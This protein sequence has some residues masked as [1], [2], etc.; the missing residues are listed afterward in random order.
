MKGRKVR[1]RDFS[2]WPHL[3]E[4]ERCRK[5]TGLGRSTILSL[6]LG[7]AVSLE[8]LIMLLQ[9]KHSPEL[10]TQS[11]RSNNA[12]SLCPVAVSTSTLFSATTLT[13]KKIIL[14]VLVFCSDPSSPKNAKCQSDCHCLFKVFPDA[15]NWSL[16]PRWNLLFCG[17]GQDLPSLSSITVHRCMCD[18]ICP[19]RFSCCNKATKTVNWVTWHPWECKS[20][21]QHPVC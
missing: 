9:E 4:E 6:N 15:R 18:G 3:Q 12:F 2:L 5:Q 11:V 1:N 8:R 20:P 13:R 19:A 21:C 7:S 17:L 14:N 16:K 10:E